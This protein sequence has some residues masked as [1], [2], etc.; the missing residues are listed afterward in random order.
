MIGSYSTVWDGWSAQQTWNLKPRN[1]VSKPDT[2]NP[3]TKTKR[4]EPSPQEASW[5]GKWNYA[6]RNEANRSN[7]RLSAYIVPQDNEAFSLISDGR[8]PTPYGQAY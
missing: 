1:Q 8:A 5:I 4:W 3:E 2:S 6:I 7:S